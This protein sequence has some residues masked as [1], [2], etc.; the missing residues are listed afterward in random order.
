M[1]QRESLAGRNSVAGDAKRRFAS[2]AT[3][4]VVSLWGGE[5]LAQLNG[6][7]TEAVNNYG[8]HNDLA[9]AINNA[10]GFATQM[11]LMSP[12]PNAWVRNIRYTDGNVFVGDFQDYQITSNS[13]D[14]DELA[15]DSPGNRI[16]Y[17][18][19]HGND[20]S[21]SGRQD[22]TGL[23]CYS[24]S[25]CPASNPFG[26]G[27]GPFCKTYPPSVNF[28]SSGSCCYNGPREL[29]SPETIGTY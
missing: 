10:D 14:W 11:A 24:A 9:N 28:G 22:G 3:V 4:A 20:Q 13:I 29:I 2:L 17:Y 27:G 25:D 7:V 8:G 5:G 26:F 21:C 12:S 23:S 19:G 6:I 18:A 15:F 1:K 16:G